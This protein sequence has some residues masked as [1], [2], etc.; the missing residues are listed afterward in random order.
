MGV[1]ARLLD[2]SC[3]SGQRTWKYD[4][5]LK[6][7]NPD[8][9]LDERRIPDPSDALILLFCD[10][11]AEGWEM[12]TAYVTESGVAG[13]PRRGYQP[14]SFVAASQYIFKRSM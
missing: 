14:C 2:W 8:G 12:V 7:R 5:Q 13:T 4:A 1:P 10:L 6:I 11:G 9:T 3:S